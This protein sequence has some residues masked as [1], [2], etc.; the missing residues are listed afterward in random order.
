MNV[1]ARRLNWA[2]LSAVATIALLLAIGVGSSDRVSANQCGASCKNSYNQ[3]RMSSK[4]S[5]SCE[6]A[7]TR[8]M[9]SC[10]LKK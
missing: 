7:F 5:P 10:I 3:C 2:L 6:I 8:C 4:G 9:Q 1:L